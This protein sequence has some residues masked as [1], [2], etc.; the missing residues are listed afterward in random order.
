[1]NF[2]P[3]Q[4]VSLKYEGARYCDMAVPDLRAA[5]VPDAV[6]FAGIKAALKTSVDTVAERQRSAI[7]TPGAGQAMEYQEAQTQAAAALKAPSKATPGLYPMLAASIGI[8][9][10]PETGAPA[11]DVLGVARSVVVSYG[12]WLSAGAAI[13]AARLAAKK[14][15]DEASTIEAAQAVIDAIVWPQRA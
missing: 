1:M 6:I 3:R 4:R 15:I 7:S 5:G 10:D 2:P 12:L 14:A 13:R 11:V 8:D 9:L